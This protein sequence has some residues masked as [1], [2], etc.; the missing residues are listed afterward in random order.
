MA[1]LQKIRKRS[2]LLLLAIGFALLAFVVQD[3]FTKGFKSQS[4]DVGSINGKD[5]SFDQFRIKVAN[6]E[7]NGQNGQPVTQTQA[8]NQMW[9]QEVAIALISEQFEKAGVRTSENNII[10]LLKKDPNIGKNPTFLNQLGKFDIAKFKEYFKNNPEQAKAFEER[11]ESDQINAKFQIYSTMIKA[12]MYTT[13]ADGQFKYKL[14]AD[15]VNFDYVSVLY[16][17]VKDSD[18]KVTDA[19]ILEYIKKNE[20]KYK[21][22]ETREIEYVLIED[23][24][25]VKDQEAMKAKIN[26]LLSPQIVFNSET[27]K[28]DT[29]PSFKNA[30]NVAE[31]VAANSDRPYDSTYVTKQDMPAEFAD[32]LFALPQ[33][34]VFGPY[35][36]GNYYYLSKAMGRKAGAKAKASHILIGWEGSKVQNQKEKRTKEQAKAKA[37]SLL[38]Q[39]QAN[40]SSFVML[41]LTNS[42]DSSAQQGG[43]LGFFSKGQ[44]VK[45]FDDY[46]FSNPIGKIGLVETEFG[47]H[48]I[49]VTDKQ[50]AVRLATIAQKIEPSET[51]SNETYTKATQFEMDA[52]TKD[53]ATV[54]KA[55]K[56]TVNPAIKAKAMDE[57]FGSA[58]NQRQIIKW[59][60]TS[61]TKVGDVKRFE[62]VNV[63]NVIARLK[64]INEKGLMTVEDAKP[65]VEGIIKNKKKAAL[66]TA[67][68]KDSSLEAIAKANATTVQNAA[69]ASVENAVLAGVGVEAKVVGTAFGSPVNKISAPIEG[70]SGVY[71]VKTKSVTKAPKLPKYDD[72][73]NKLKAS[74]AQAAGRV[75]P[76][77]KNDAKIEDNRLEF[78]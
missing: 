37:E 66:I 33:G 51:T 20:K 38:A 49:N 17:T 55:A 42:D 30:T 19:D 3:L 63:G 8:A 32:Q 46:V 56:L 68:M 11:E 18:V 61:D 4:K 28:N 9:D 60:Y 7:K 44:M 1:V 12:G 23:K 76:A 70:N 31:F 48:I 71:V 15:K 47:Y 50:D 2:G 43:D 35:I 53:F 27:K 34:E 5:I 77:L 10:E 72:Y 36:S 57:A 22:E 67:K 41:A 52:Q 75:F 74:N 25:S 54:A 16:S 21:S 40:P 24:P 62:I 73:V 78:F 6:A 58:G 69:A 14:E 59:A 65:G 26:A 13:T 39:A 29:L 64:K 45:P